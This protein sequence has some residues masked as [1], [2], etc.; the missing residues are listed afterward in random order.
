[1]GV[2]GYSY[3]EFLWEKEVSRWRALELDLQAAG[4]PGNRHVVANR[5]PRTMRGQHLV[6][7]VPIRREMHGLYSHGLGCAGTSSGGTSMRLA[8]PHKMACH[9]GMKSELERYILFWK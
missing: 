5:R 4:G 6:V 3:Y 7:R 8:S 9:G 1:M 2:G